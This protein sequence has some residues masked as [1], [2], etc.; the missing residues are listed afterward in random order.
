MNARALVSKLSVILG[1]MLFLA[2]VIWAAED[3]P[4]EEENTILKLV[5]KQPYDDGGYTV[6]SSKTYLFNGSGS[7]T[8]KQFKERKKYIVDGLQTNGVSLAKL[9]DRL[10][11]RNKKSEQL[12]IESSLKDGYLIDAD[13][14]YEAYFKKDGG[15]WKKWHTENPKAHG[16]TTVSLPIYDQ[17]TGLFL[18]YMGFQS[19]PLAG[20]G[21]V[22]LFRFKD[23]ELKELNR[24]MMWIS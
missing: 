8:Y 12:T 7:D 5:L 14:K 18:I 11:E 22:I 2:P 19:G 13:H 3:K 1:A 9:V 17:K 24:V 21:F 10:F 6:V 20:E 23:G 15:G 4:T 16:S